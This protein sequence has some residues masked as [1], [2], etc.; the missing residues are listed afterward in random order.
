MLVLWRPLRLDL[1]L[2]VAHNNQVIDSHIVDLVKVVK[3]DLQVLRRRV[4][5][6][7]GHHAIVPSLRDFGRDGLMEFCSSVVRD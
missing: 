3:A 4:S 5:R 1:K 2:L 6:V 7:V